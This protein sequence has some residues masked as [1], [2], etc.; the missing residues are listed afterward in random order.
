M[1]YDSNTTRSPF[2]Q[3][4]AGKILAF[5]PLDGTVPVLS[6]QTLKKMSAMSSLVF[7]LHD[8]LLLD[9]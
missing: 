6:I 2:I 1:Y 7:Y 3:H 8:I 9:V 5:L 4:D